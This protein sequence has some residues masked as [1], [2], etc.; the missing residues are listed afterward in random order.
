MFNTFSEW[1][2]NKYVSTSEKQDGSKIT[3]GS[4]ST[5]ILLI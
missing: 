2:A 5:G 4:R 1:R 3:L